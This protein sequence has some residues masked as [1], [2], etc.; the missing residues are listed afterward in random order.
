MCF[1][2]EN[3]IYSTVEC[4]ISCLKFDFKSLK[5]SRGKCFKEFHVHTVKK[6][7]NIQNCIFLM[8]FYKLYFSL[9]TDRL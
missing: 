7:N 8:N 6:L 5:N 2:L 1:L 9:Y 4:E 3:L